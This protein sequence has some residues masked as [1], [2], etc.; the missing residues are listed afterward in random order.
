[1]LV[2]VPGNARIPLNADAEQAAE[3][4]FQSLET[5]GTLSHLGL[6]AEGEGI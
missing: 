6:L 1:L 3:S 4:L 5:A 2:L